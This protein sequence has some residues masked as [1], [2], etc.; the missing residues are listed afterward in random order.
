MDDNRLESNQLKQSHVFDHPFF[1]LF[2]HHSAA[3]V[4]H[5]NNLSVKALDIRQGFNQ[6]LRF[7]QI[8]LHI[9]I[10]NFHPLLNSGNRR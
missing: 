3:A 10:H 2:I 8:L 9:F 6:D 7:I 1:Q 5:Y 4:F